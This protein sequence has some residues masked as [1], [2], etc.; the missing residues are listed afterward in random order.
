MSEMIRFVPNNVKFH[1]RRGIGLI[2]REGIWW[3]H[4]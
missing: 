3:P 4:L 1:K 2:A